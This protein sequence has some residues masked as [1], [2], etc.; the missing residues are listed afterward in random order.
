MHKLWICTCSIL[1][2][3]VLFFQQTGEAVEENESLHVKTIPVQ[4][5]TKQKMEDWTLQY[6]IKNQDLFVE[7]IV[8][9]FSL[10]KK[11]KEGHGYL[12]VKMNGETAAHMGQAA[13]VMK[14][15]PAGKHTIKV[16][17]VSY[18]GNTKKDAVT[19]EV[20]VPSS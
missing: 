13:F 10:S 14:N 18:D 17:P 16:Q 8:P 5:E 1:M 11:E 4:S 15:L 2:V 3:V 7:C 6:K 19:F 9:E 12:L 20:E